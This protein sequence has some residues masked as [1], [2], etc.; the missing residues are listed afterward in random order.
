MKF[1]KERVLEIGRGSTSPPCVENLLW[2]RLWVSSKTDNRMKVLIN[3][4]GMTI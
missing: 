1:K 3:E 4:L 2:K